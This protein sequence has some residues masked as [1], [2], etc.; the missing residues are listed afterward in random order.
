[1][2][3]QVVRGVAGVGS[4]V[5]NSLTLADERER[6]AESVMRSAPH[7]YA[8]P[9]SPHY[10]PGTRC[11]RSRNPGLGIMLKATRDRQVGDSIIPGEHENIRFSP[12]TVTGDCG[13][14][15]TD[16]TDVIER[17]VNHRYFK[18]GVVVDAVDAYRDDR[19]QRAAAFK[20]QL[21]ADPL[22]AEEFAALGDSAVETF[23]DVA[24]APEQKPARR[25]TGRQH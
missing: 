10:R 19:V 22:L 14:L 18:I 5:R 3:A 13:E 4:Q 7:P 9:K 8:D 17:I 23:A 20:Q 25:R 21:A 2:H 12:M 16:R 11:F 1:M 6:K 15:V 24:E